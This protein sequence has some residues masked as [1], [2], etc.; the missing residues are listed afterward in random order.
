MEVIFQPVGLLANSR[1]L[2]VAIP[3]VEIGCLATPEGSQKTDGIL[4]CNDKATTPPGSII[5]PFSLLKSIPPPRP[6]ACHRLYAHLAQLVRCAPTAG[7][8]PD[9]IQPERVQR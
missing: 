4:G 7:F 2:S 6:R 5:Y 1:W 8:G 3:Q 9:F